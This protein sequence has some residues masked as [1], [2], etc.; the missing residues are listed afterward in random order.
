M[1]DQ[2]IIAGIRP[3]H[4]HIQFE[5]SENTVPCS[6]DSVELI[7]SELLVEAVLDT[8]EA[9]TLRLP[10]LEMTSRERADLFEGNKIYLT[11]PAKA[12]HLFDRESGTNLIYA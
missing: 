6:I 7:G 3:E 8:D 9:V 2:D 5:E 1:D 10:V 12:L 11:F 4:I